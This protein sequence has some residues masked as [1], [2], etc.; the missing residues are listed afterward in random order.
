MGSADPRSRPAP[1]AKPGEWSGAKH[2]GEL[3]RARV[4]CAGPDRAIL[5]K[6]ADRLDRRFLFVGLTELWD[7]SLCLFHRLL[8]A[9]PLPGDAQVSNAQASSG[10]RPHKHAAFDFVDVADELLFSRVLD[11]FEADVAC[12]VAELRR[13]GDT[14]SCARP[15][16]TAAPPGG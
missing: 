1:A 4:D 9:A 6:A 7:L 3:C 12:V 2:R 13:A 11:R 5:A 10:A 8:G 15:G 14:R 16:P